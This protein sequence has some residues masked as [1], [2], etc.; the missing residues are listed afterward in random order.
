MDFTSQWII[1]KSIGSIDASQQNFAIQVI[2]KCPSFSIFEWNLQ[3]T[4]ENVQN[5][6]H[7]FKPPIW[8]RFI[9]V[10]G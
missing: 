6:V 5:F 1:N 8:F 3:T 2:H 4:F 9:I 10:F 7:F